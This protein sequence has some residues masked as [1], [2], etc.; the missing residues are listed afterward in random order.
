M[1]DLSPRIIDTTAA[2]G[3]LV[4]LLIDVPNNPP[5]I[6][7]DLEGINLSRHGSISIMQIYLFPRNEVYL[8]YVHT[9]GQ[10]AFSHPSTS[11]ATLKGILEDESIQKALVDARNDSDAL[12]A[13][14]RVHLAGIQ[15]IQLL[16]L[17][18]RSGSRRF[19]NGL[20]RCIERDA[21]LTRSEASAWKI[22]KDN[23]RRLFAPERGGSYEVFNSRPLSETIIKY[24]AQ[25]VRI[26]P[27][28]WAFYNGKLGGRLRGK[29]EVATSDRI[30]VCFQAEYTGVGRH[31]AESPSGLV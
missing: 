25:D 2:I 9:L 20:A 28:L 22:I 13:H 4:E 5:S 16:E 1:I 10:D 21:S 18:T 30:N 27:K 8:I 14:F 6:Y 3:E 29:L 26:L 17:A 12:Y 7:V 23:G 24:C 15:D 19:I 11:G 31:M